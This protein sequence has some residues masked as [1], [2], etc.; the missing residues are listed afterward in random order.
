MLTVSRYLLADEDLAVEW[1]PVLSNVALLTL[2]SIGLAAI[3]GWVSGLYRRRY[4]VGSLDELRIPTIV[5][6]SVWFVFAI[7]YSI[8]G[9]AT[10]RKTA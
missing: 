4:I 6:F 10:R 5:T 2:M 7:V 8:Q 3:G 9:S 1:T